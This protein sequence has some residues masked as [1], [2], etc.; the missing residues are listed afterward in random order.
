MDT[1]PNKQREKSERESNGFRADSSN[2][3]AFTSLPVGSF[4]GTLELIVR[5][6][7]G[8]RV[9]ADTGDQGGGQN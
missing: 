7:D 1:Q 6:R 5:I 3:S 4:A 2:E 8:R 9:P